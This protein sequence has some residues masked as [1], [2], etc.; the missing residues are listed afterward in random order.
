[1]CCKYLKGGG[2]DDGAQRIL[3]GAQQLDKM[4]KAQTETQDPY[5]CDKYIF[6]VKATEY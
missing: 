4:K 1:M 2:Q 3:S 5:E 6:T